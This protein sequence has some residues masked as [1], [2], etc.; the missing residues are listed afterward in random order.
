MMIINVINL[1]QFYEF[2][3]CRYGRYYLPSLRSLW[4]LLEQA[5]YA[6]G[7]RVGLMANAGMLSQRSVQLWSNWLQ[8][9]ASS[10]CLSLSSSSFSSFRVSVFVFFVYHSVV[11]W[12]VLIF[13][14]SERT[15]DNAP[16]SPV[17][18]DIHNELKS[19]L[20]HERR[21]CAFQ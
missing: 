8:P 21:P 4:R 19:H 14:F 11:G 3:R 15:I 20:I 6:W 9:S 17:L 5:V 13:F 18:W 7:S 1:R 16:A 2:T 10:L 12:Q